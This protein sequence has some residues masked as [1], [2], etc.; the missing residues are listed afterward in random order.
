M[1]ASPGICRG[2]HASPT[3]GSHTRYHLQHERKPQLL[4]ECDII[5]LKCRTPGTWHKRYNLPGPSAC[6]RLLRKQ[7][8]SKPVISPATETNNRPGKERQHRTLIKRYQW[9]KLLANCLSFS[10]NPHSRYQWVLSFLI[11][12]IKKSRIKEFK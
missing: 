5:H 11:L 4:L 2:S 6:R 10:R 1:Q 9:C 3:R 8:G 7:P 12:Q